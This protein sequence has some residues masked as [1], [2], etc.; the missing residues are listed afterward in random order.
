MAHTSTP[1]T[2]AETVAMA[3]LAAASALLVCADIAGSFLIRDS[4][5]QGFGWSDG[6]G[7]RKAEVAEAPRDLFK[8]GRP[9]TVHSFMCDDI[10]GM[11]A[12]VIA[13]GFSRQK[14]RERMLANALERLSDP[15]QQV[16]VVCRDGT[17]ACAYWGE[18]V[19]DGVE[20]Y[21]CYT[22]VVGTRITP[23]KHGAEALMLRSILAT[24]R[25]GGWL[26][27]AFMRKPRMERHAVEES[28]GRLLGQALGGIP[29]CGAAAPTQ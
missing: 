21:V 10:S 4:S 27:G 15:P 6:A 7:W 18:F 26:V 14:A 28:L 25:N 8:F 13:A 12:R 23:R 29:P 22:Y 9:D 11:H 20:H 24:R 2:W 1:R 5:V 3:A 19:L 17:Q 16:S